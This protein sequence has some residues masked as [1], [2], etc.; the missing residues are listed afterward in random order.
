MVQSDTGGKINHSAITIHGEAVPYEIYFVTNFPDEIH[1]P[2][3]V[4]TN[5]LTKLKVHSSSSWTLER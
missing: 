5:T 2:S 1:N 4:G 3:Y